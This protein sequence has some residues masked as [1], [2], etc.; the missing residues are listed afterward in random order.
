MSD[1]NL[2]DALKKAK[3]A[4]EA[5]AH[6]ADDGTCNFDSV[7]LFPGRSRKKIEAALKEADIGFYENQWM[8]QKG[9]FLRLSD[10]QAARRTAMAEAAYEVLKETGVDVSMYYQM[11]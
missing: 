3:E 2:V 7:V 1:V 11:D 8:G 4:A 10:G 9:L 5:H 6:D